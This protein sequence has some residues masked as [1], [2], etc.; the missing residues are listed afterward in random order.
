M[1]MAVLVLQTLAIER[2][3]PRC[4][5]E[6]KSAAALIASRPREIADALKP[7]HR[8]ENVERHHRHVRGRIARCGSDP[9]RHRTR[10]VDALL[11]HLPGLVFFVEHQLI[12]ILRTIKLPDLTED[13]ELPEHAFHAKRAAFVRHDRYD[14]TA[15]FLVAH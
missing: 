2:R 14:A 15:E 6:Q 7:E 9:R 4:A 10:L 5:A 3:A 11:Q 13:A 1:A 12:R 8:I